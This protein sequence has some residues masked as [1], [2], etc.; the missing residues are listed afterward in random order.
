MKFNCDCC[1]LCCRNVGKTFLQIDLDRGDGV[2]KNLTEKNLCRI[3]KNRPLI[4]NVDAYWEKFLSSIISREEFYKINYK[5]CEE[6]KKV[7]GS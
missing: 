4:C 2:C 7:V 6:L 3:Y 1:G 5:V